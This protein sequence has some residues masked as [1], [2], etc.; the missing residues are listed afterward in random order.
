MVASGLG[1][2]ATRKPGCLPGPRVLVER[3]GVLT[4][5]VVAL[6]P[7]A[8]SW[9]ELAPLLSR[10][11]WRGELRRGYFVEGLSGVQYAS[12]EAAAELARL[13]AGSPATPAAARHSS[14]H[15]RSGE[16]LRGRRTAG[17]RAPGRR[18]RAAAA[19]ARAIS[20]SSATAVP[21]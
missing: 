8:P 5:E 11:E 15:D 12:E 10:A 6:E 9:G 17:H 14:S 1:R 16:H 21:S 3:Y 18:R 4:R 7:S 19:A 2:P 13:A 20:W